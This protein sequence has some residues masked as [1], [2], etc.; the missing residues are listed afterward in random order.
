MQLN[1]DCQKVID[2]FNQYNQ[3]NQVSISRAEF[4]KNLVLKMELR[5][6]TGDVKALLSD[7][8]NWS[9]A[10]AY[11]SV[12]DCLVS[13]LAGLPWKNL[14]KKIYENSD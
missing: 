1:M 14:D 2:T 3:A 10:N 8:I 5:E 4:E 13:Q 12:M 9:P 7:G 11:S 6:F